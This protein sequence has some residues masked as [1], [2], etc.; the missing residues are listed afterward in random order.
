[1]A[2]FRPG[3]IL[4]APIG[5]LLVEAE[6]GAARV[7]AAGAHALLDEL[8]A[9]QLPLAAVGDAGLGGRGLAT[10]LERHGLR[11]SFACIVPGPG[12]RA[13]EP[14]PRP[15][16]EALRRL[17]VPAAR[18]WHVGGSFGRDVTVAAAAGVQAVW[19]DAGDAPAPAP[20]P[21]RRVRCLGELLALYL[22]SQRAGRGARVRYPDAGGAGT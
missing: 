10:L 14:D 3:A 4:F 6:P 7:P 5:T 16:H 1:M 17:R 19:L 20:A 12:D 22:E 21:H 18:A 11:R 9:D 15:L 8:A 2:P 13:H